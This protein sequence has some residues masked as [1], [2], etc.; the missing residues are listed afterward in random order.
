[1]HRKRLQLIHIA[2][3]SYISIFPNHS[4]LTPHP[5]LA[6]LPILLPTPSLLILPPPTETTSFCASQML[7]ISLVSSSPAMEP[8]WTGASSR[9]RSPF[10]APWWP[11]GELSRSSTITR[12]QRR[13]WGA[14]V[15]TRA[16]AFPQNPLPRIYRDHRNANYYR[17]VL[18]R[19]DSG[20]AN[21]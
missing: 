13:L 15:V 20:T 5:F 2:V 11:S 4:T 19:N 14:R 12:L 6:L 18:A 3:N 9:R 21:Y 17:Q 16:A 10:S 1:M 7:G 8:R